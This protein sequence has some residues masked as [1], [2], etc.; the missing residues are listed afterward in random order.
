[1]DSKG[2]PTSAGKGFVPPA[3]QHLQTSPIQPVPQP[4]GFGE[5]LP[6][7]LTVSAATGTGTAF[8]ITEGRE[9][10]I[11]KQNLGEKCTDIRTKLENNEMSVKSGIHAFRG[12]G[13]SK[14]NTI[15]ELKKSGRID[16]TEDYIMVDWHTVPVLKTRKNEVVAPDS[17]HPDV[18]AYVNKTRVQVGKS[19]KA[20]QKFYDSLTQEQKDASETPFHALQTELHQADKNIY[21]AQCILASTSKKDSA[22]DKTLDCKEYTC[23]A[24][25]VNSKLDN[26][27]S[28]QK[29]FGSTVKLVKE[30]T[31]NAISPGAPKGCGSI[32]ESFVSKSTNPVF[33]MG[34]MPL[35]SQIAPPQKFSNSKSSIFLLSATF[36]FIAL[37]SFF[38]SQRIKREDSEL[39]SL[40]Y[41]YK[42]GKIS[43][44]ETKKILLEKFKF[45][46]TNIKQILEKI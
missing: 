30:E 17:A 22:M 31:S 38:R 26:A 7:Y 15:I 11:Y 45:S 14:G 33:V 43:S 20:N 19:L 23:K 40:L 12:L 34:E 21:E 37:Y 2:I 9:Q 16:P 42:I 8:L 10:A 1:M 44:M 4:R 3:T 28:L 18:L 35:Q 25:E 5:R 46:E 24:Q 39:L 36:F 13:I 29:E 41:N 6:E 27:D 32:T